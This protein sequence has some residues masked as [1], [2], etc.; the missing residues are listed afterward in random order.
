MSTER[1]RP[2]RATQYFNKL[3]V[4]LAGRRVAPMWALV[5]HTGRTSGRTYRTPV[6]V[7]AAPGVF[8]VGLPWGRSSD[9]VRNLR[10]AGGGTVRWRGT[11]YTVSDPTFVDR[12]EVL[13]AARTPQRQMMSRWPLED[14][15]RLRRVAGG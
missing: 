15:L 7:I 8:Y 3:A 13:A 12:D 2:P 4:H 6:A 11:P 1:R 9:W 10:A 5:E 14:F